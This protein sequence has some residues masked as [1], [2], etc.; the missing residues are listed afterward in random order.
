[1]PFFPFARLSNSLF[2]CRIF[3][4]PLAYYAFQGHKLLTAHPLKGTTD[5]WLSSLS[6][7]S[8]EE[9]PIQWAGDPAVF[10]GKMDLTLANNT[11]NLIH[12]D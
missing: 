2:H 3:H 4:R 6:I 10:K 12:Y 9:V 11:I 7:L 5:L 1:M 8:E